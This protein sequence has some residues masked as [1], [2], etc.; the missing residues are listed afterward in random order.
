MAPEACR[1]LFFSGGGSVW[2]GPFRANL[3][4]ACFLEML[5]TG[6]ER[7]FSL[8]QRA[9]ELQQVILRDIFYLMNKSGEG[10]LQ[11]LERSLLFRPSRGGDEG[12]KVSH[13]LLQGGRHDP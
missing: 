7:L 5:K 1:R 6:L 13:A 3:R 2:R 10:M 4:W 8:F 12:T 9:G 11:F